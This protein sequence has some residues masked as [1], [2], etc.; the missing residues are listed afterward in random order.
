MKLFDKAIEVK[1]RTNKTN[2]QINFSIPKRDFSKED[3]E[4][5]CLAKRFK[6]RI[7]GL[8]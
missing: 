4:K 2:G 8:W 7:E 5:L 6:I 1:S 3:I